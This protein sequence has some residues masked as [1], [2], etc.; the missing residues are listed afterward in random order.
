MKST[1][2]FQ[3]PSHRG[4]GF[5]LADL[6]VGIFILSLLATV[7]L[8]SL[9]LRINGAGKLESQRNATEAAQ[10]VLSNLQNGRPIGEA[11]FIRLTLRRSGQKIGSSE[12][13]EV[14]ISLDGRHATLSGLA[15]TTQEGQR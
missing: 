11:D 9:N 14:T 4:R 15:P 5:L 3:I 12:W 10:R 6:M 8:M 2:H 1:V 13:V 7:L